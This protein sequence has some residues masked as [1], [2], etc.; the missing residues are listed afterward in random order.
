MDQILPL[1]TTS[2]LTSME[3]LVLVMWKFMP[4]YSI[5][6]GPIRTTR[7]SRPDGPPFPGDETYVDIYEFT[8][9]N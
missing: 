9:L 4:S 3:F 7:V 8:A 1:R 2:V 6:L 5:L